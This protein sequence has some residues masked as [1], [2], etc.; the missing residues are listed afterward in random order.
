M[1]NELRE[2]QRVTTGVNVE[3]TLDRLRHEVNKAQKNSIIDDAIEQTRK[4]QRTIWNL[5]ALLGAIN[6]ELPCASRRGK[7]SC[8]LKV[9]ECD[10]WACE[11]LDTINDA[12]K[13]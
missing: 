11:R 5:R 2:G 7:L 8:E 4:D 9:G 12:L 3:N 1:T 13:D 10:C 6:D